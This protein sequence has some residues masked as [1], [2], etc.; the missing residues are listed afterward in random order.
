MSLALIC[1]L[2]GAVVYLAVRWG[3]ARAENATLRTHIE[4]LKRRLSR[5]D[6]R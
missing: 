5:R 2:A 6:S 4:Q 1:V 3:G